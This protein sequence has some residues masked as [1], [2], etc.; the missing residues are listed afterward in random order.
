HPGETAEDFAQTLALCATIRFDKIHIAAFSARPGTL[1]AEQE[2]DPALA[3]TEA[4]KEARRR[5]L[6]QLHER[7]ATELNAQYLNQTVEV[8]VE[9]ENRGKWRGRN[10]QNKLVFFTHADDL[11]GQ[12]VQVRITHTG[13]WSLQGQRVG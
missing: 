10:P 6:E 13:P 7:V 8:L 11:T 5:T 1:A 4:E 12:L 3:V 9:G 2:Q